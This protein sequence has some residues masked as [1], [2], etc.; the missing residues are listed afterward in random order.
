M[1]RH[2]AMAV[3]VMGDRRH[4]LGHRCVVNGR[5]N[6]VNGS[7]MVDG[8]SNVV[9]WSG[10]DDLVHGLRNLDVAGL[11]VDNGVESVM[12]IGSVLNGAFVS[13]RVDQAV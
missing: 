4:N 10:V 2:V 5:G 6:V 13:V 8:R 9:N 12:V 11:T 1:H 3:A 7:H